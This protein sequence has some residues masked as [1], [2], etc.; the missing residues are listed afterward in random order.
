MRGKRLVIALALALLIYLIL[1][2]PLLISEEA[3]I[4]K[5]VKE[6]V[7]AIEN[8]DLGKC[9]RHVSLHYKD[10]YGLT[11]LGVKKLLTQIFYEFDAFEIDLRNLR[12]TLLDKG[13]ASATF[14]LK[15]K[16]NYGGQR[17]YLLG[18]GGFS[19][20]IKMSFN[21][22]RGRWKV[23]QVEGVQAHGIGQGLPKVVRICLDNTV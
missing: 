6:G 5:G 10:E 13:V 22:E 4:R 12:I 14:D 20:R 9:L 19:N 15:V 16:V 8:K 18:S 23:T 3:R 1:V 21:K 11:Y 17:I 7:Q 2:R